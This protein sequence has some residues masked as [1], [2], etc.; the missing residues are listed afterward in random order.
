MWTDTTVMMLRRILGGVLCLV[1]DLAQP[2]KT[3]EQYNI[4]QPVFPTINPYPTEEYIQLQC[5]IIYKSTVQTITTKYIKD[6][7]KMG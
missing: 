4:S 7:K 5:G 1:R 3:G 2:P 6:Q